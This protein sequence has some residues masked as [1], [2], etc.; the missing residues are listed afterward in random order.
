MS[1]GNIRLLLMW[2]HKSKL[3]YK[4]HRDTADY[5]DNL[6]KCLGFPA[7]LINVFNTTSLFSSYL[8]I[9]SLFLLFIA[10][11]SLISA[12]L[13]AC[14]NYFEFNNKSQLHK[15]M[16]IEYSKILYSIEKIIILIKND[17]SF[18]LNQ[19]VMNTTLNSFEKLREVFIY[20]PEN[21]WIKNNKLF[22]S[23]LDDLDVNTSD[24]VN[25]ILQ[26]IKNKKNFSFDDVDK[27][28]EII[29]YS[30]VTK[31]NKSDTKNE[32]NSE[33]SN[34]DNNSDTKNKNNSVSSN[35]DN[36]SDTKN[37]NNSNTINDHVIVNIK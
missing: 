15:K 7:I 11:L 31:K 36:K 19:D 1:D 25:I 26:S 34:I 37:E 30:N 2:Y 10:I 4:C 9:N 20:F 18:I 16:M 8:S 23:K 28:S 29:T 32:N 24:S 21:I 12:M 27:N 5:Y 33:S 14:Q 35:I 22:K 13:T 3:Y 6:N 17:D